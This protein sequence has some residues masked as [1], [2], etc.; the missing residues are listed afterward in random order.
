M[1]K[2]AQRIGNGVG[3]SLGL[4]TVLT[5]GA[6]AA[7]Q[8]VRIEHL[9]VERTPAA[10]VVKGSGVAAGLNAGGIPESETAYVVADVAKGPALYKWPVLP[11][12]WVARQPSGAET[13]FCVGRKM[14]KRE[15]RDGTRV[16]VVG[17]AMKMLRNAPVWSSYG[18]R[19]QWQRRAPD[20]VRF[21]FEGTIALEY[22]DKPMRVRAYVLIGKVVSPTTWPTRTVV[23]H[24]AYTGSVQSGTFVGQPA[25]PRVPVRPPHRPTVAHDSAGLLKAAGQRLILQTRDFLT[26]C[27]LKGVDPRRTAEALKLAI[28][29]GRRDSS[30]PRYDSRTATLYATAGHLQEYLTT[31]IHHERSAARRMTPVGLSYAA[32]EMLYCQIGHFLNDQLG[33]R[34]LRPHV[35]GAVVSP[36]QRAQPQIAFRHAS[37]DLVCELM[38]RVLG[39]PIRR[40]TGDFTERNALTVLKRDPQATGNE[41]P[42]VVT[43]F[44]LAVLPKHPGAAY[45]MFCEVRAAAPGRRLGGGAGSLGTWLGHCA[46]LQTAHARDITRDLMIGQAV[47][48]YR[49]APGQVP[50]AYELSNPAALVKLTAGYQQVRPGE[51]GQV[52]KKYLLDAGRPVRMKLVGG[53]VSLSV[54]RAASGAALGLSSTG[55]D[56]GLTIGTDGSVTVSVYGGSVNL[57][58]P[59]GQGVAVQAGSKHVWPGQAWQRATAVTAADLRRAHEERIRAEKALMELITTRS[60]DTHANEIRRAQQEYFR[61]NTRYLDL[62]RRVPPE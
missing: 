59:N 34:R 30:G 3:A 60:L 19:S 31:E 42:G 46:L 58:L 51:P 38:G 15:E 4:L 45:R 50:F 10:F 56:C 44:L 7:G 39:R 5:F 24:V 16:V 6:V 23:H 11:D 35:A 27:G 1:M 61:A 53:G 26:Q 14:L 62:L 52:V 41:I 49:I 33:Y 21:T 48:A 9:T 32:H 43:T 8:T 17:I 18:G 36:W 37:A 54:A 55:T 13:H 22:A 20:T 28:Q 47:R 29:P 57:Q 40:A 2:A 25:R 12:G